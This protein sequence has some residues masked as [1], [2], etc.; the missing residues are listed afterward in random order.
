MN[1]SHMLSKV[2]DEASIYNNLEQKQVLVMQKAATIIKEHWKEFRRKRV[3]HYY[4][5]M[6]E[7]NKPIYFQDES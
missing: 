6:F 2:P 7:K 4:S 1:R 3:I 5:K